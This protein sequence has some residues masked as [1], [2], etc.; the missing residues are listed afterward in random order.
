MP[1][2]R[3][4]HLADLIAVF[5]L[6]ILAP[7]HPEPGR[8]HKDLRPHLKKEICILRDPHIIGNAK[9]HR[10]RHMM[11]IDR[12][13]TPIT[14][15]VRL[16]GPVRALLGPVVR[17]LPRILRAAVTVP[18]CISPCRVQKMI[19]VGLQIAG[20]LRKCIGKKRKHEKLGV[21]ER[22]SSILLAVKKL[23][24]DI[25]TVVRFTCRTH[26]ME[27]VETDGLVKLC[28][29]VN[30]DIRLLPELLTASSVSIKLCLKACL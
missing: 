10:G 5:F 24:P 30:P 11:L 13:I 16:D 23:R 21:P 19:A 28:V 17:R 12:N 6:Y 20:F 9:R 18:R 1:L 3:P 27:Y 14:G 26:Q 25:H 2:V 8:F 7:A 29:S 22:M 4:C 15:S